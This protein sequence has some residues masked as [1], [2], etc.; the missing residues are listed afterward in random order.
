M[1]MAR[2]RRR[3]VDCDCLRV[4]DWERIWKGS[5]IIALLQEIGGRRDSNAGRGCDA[6]SNGC[7]T[8]GGRWTVDR[9]GKNGSY[10]V[11]RQTGWYGFLATDVRATDGHSFEL[12]TLPRD[13]RQT[14]GASRR[15]D[16]TTYELPLR[17]F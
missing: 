3:P 6:N 9:L 15:R 16:R 13:G 8:I 7:S 10:Q 12:P 1:A 14:D 5:E 11:E 4:A 17:S 2:P